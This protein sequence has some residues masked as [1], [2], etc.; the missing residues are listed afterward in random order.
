[1]NEIES[2]A[3][4]HLFQYQLDSGYLYF[5]NGEPVTDPRQL[6]EAIESNRIIVSVNPPKS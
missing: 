2:R 1:M 3:L 6:I 5:V 4:Y